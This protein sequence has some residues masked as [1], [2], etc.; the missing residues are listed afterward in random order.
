M[1]VS[2][3]WSVSTEMLAYLAFPVLAAV[4][5]HGQNATA[6][7]TGAVAILAVIACVRLAPDAGRGGGRAQ[8]L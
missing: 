7:M 1:I 6:W 8:Y 5:L 4:A 3:G 2:P